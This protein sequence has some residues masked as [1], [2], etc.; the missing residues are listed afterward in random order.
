MSDSVEY[1]TLAR[2]RDKLVTAFKLDA[3]TIADAFVSRSLISAAI[4]SEVNELA[5]SEQKARRLADCVFG[6]VQISPH[7]Q[8]GN[9]MSVFSQLDWL[10]DL[11]HIL[12]STHS[13]FSVRRPVALVVTAIPYSLKFSGVTGQ[14]LPRKF[15]PGE[16]IS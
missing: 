4:A 9:F 8:Y 5:T 10:K 13:K 7:T 6:Q 14:D 1:R 11:V 15:S 16:R 12:N 2:C 3:V